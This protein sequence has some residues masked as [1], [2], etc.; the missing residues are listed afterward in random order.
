M[1]SRESFISFLYKIKYVFCLA[2][3]KIKWS[4]T[5][6]HNFTKAENLF[7]ID[8]VTVGNYTYGP[9]HIHSYGNPD[10][11]L[12]IG[13]FCSIAH[14]VLFLLGG[15]HRYDLLS[16]YPFRKFILGE[17]HVAK[18]KGPIIVEDDVWIGMN[19]MILSGVT[20]GKGAVIAAGSVVAKDIPPYAVYAGNRV[21]KY[22]FPE[23][24]I[25]E[26]LQIDFG[27]INAAFII[28]NRKIFEEGNIETQVDKLKEKMN[29]RNLS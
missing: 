22:R 13:H 11:R 3:F 16:T 17:R 21:V 18:T 24:T 25:E 1:R 23:Q 19:T 2:L 5:N 26:L 28:K 14:N 12:R 10:E 4:K 20:I 8:K 7:P 15:E 6:N 9:L 29:E 27:K